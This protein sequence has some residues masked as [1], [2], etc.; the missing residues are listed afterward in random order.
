MQRVTAFEP[1][2]NQT[3]PFVMNLSSTE[4]LTPLTQ[5]QTLNEEE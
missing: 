1:G 3:Q 2:R 4:T 5:A